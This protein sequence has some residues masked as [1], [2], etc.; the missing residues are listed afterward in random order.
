MVSSLGTDRRF[1]VY[2][3]TCHSSYVERYCTLCTR[4]FWDLET[5]CYEIVNFM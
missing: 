4:I 3:I 1:T 2:L 5:D